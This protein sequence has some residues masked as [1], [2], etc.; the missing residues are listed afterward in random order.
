MQKGL[1]TGPSGSI[2]YTRDLINWRDYPGNPVLNAIQRSWQ[3]P[4]RV[5]TP[6]LRTTSTT[7]TPSGIPTKWRPLV[8]R[9]G[10]TVALAA[11]E[12][13]DDGRLLA[14]G[15]AVSGLDGR[16]WSIRD[17]AIGEDLETEVYRDMERF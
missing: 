14:Y 4:H 5:H 2:A 13:R 17:V 10:S 16:E 8:I 6:T 1:T 3:T 9:Q 15:L 11:W 12:V 7:W